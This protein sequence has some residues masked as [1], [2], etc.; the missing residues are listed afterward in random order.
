VKHSTTIS[1]V[2][3][4]A[5]WAASSV[6][7]ASVDGVPLDADV[8]V[9]GEAHDTAAHHL[10]QA[11]WIARMRP[12]AVVFEMLPSELGDVATERAGAAADDLAAALRWAER[13]WPDFALYAPVFD[14]AAG[15]EIFGAEAPRAT[16]AAA[17]NDGAWVAFGAE[18]AFGLSTDLPDAE[19]QARMALQDAA[20]CGLLPEEMLPGMV[21]AQR[22]R[23]A[24][25]AQAVLDALSET[26]GPVA[27][28][29][30]NGHARIDWGVPA[31]L[32]AARPEL[33]VTSIGQF[34]NPDVNAPYDHVVV[35]PMAETEGDP[36]AALR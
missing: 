26:G 30:G 35:S 8:V 31:L 1:L 7:A 3:G 36:C 13:G 24:W 34:A 12:S 2:I 29:T 27:V 5:L 19:L 11:A 16:V 33:R 25:L 21:E 10:N 14:A 28:V 17:A 6:Y 20:H 4:A 15:A 22:L 23:D 9:M 18:D 32:R